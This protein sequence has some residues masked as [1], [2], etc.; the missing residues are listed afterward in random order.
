[1]SAEVT[2]VNMLAQHYFVDSFGKYIGTIKMLEDHFKTH[3]ADLSEWEAHLEEL[4][5]VNDRHYQNSQRGRSPWQC[6]S[7]RPTQKPGHRQ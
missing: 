1:M 5:I 2:K 7:S 6:A 4:K 3:C